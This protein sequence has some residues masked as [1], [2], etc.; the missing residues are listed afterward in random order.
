M[1]PELLD[2]VAAAHARLVDVVR[3]LDDETARRP[4]LLPDWS[5]GHVLTHVARNADSFTHLCERAAAGEVADQYPGGPAQRAADIEAGAGRPARE[6]VEDVRAACARLERAFAAVTDWGAPCRVTVGEVTLRRL[7]FSRRRE[8]EIH[9]ADLGFDAFTW[10]DWS[11]DFVEAELSALGPDR[12][13]HLLAFLAGR[14]DPPPGL[15]A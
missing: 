15:F 12:R 6:L 9:T 2:A 7:P 4:S 11:D 3:D 13:R 5:V 1:T 10:R 14:A 8:V